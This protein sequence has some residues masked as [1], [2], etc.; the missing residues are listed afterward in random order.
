MVAWPRGGPQETVASYQPE[1]RNAHARGIDGFA[2]NCG[3]WD[4]SEPHYKRRVLRL[5]D[6]A[7]SL[8][9]D[10]KLF[11]SADGRAQDELKDIVA[12]T[13]GLKA[14]LHV[15]GKPVLSAYAAGGKGFT[16][17]TALASEAESPGTFFVPHFFPATGERQISARE[18]AQSRNVL[19]V[20]TVI[21]T[22]AR[23]VRRT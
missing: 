14:Q 13:R 11:V 5:Y 21:S 16:D 10:F 8:D 7:A 23:R 20:R 3:G 22:S 12:T 6:A 18:A 15:D 9:F 17:S 2:L 4:A 19:A 1:F